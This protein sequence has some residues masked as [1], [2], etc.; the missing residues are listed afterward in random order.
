MT[1]DDKQTLSRAVQADYWRSE[2]L[3]T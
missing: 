1:D 3:E 2:F